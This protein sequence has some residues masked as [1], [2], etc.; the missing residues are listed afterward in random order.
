[1]YTIHYGETIRV[2]HDHAI[3]TARYIGP[4]REVR[5][6]QSVRVSLNGWH[7]LDLPLRPVRACC[8]PKCIPPVRKCCR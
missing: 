7:C 1:M 3:Y 4:T 6:G 2:G 8:Q 5:A